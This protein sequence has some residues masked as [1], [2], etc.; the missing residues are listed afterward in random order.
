MNI[1]ID[2]E[3]NQI[4]EE[5]NQIEEIDEKP[6]KNKRNVKPLTEEQKEQKHILIGKARDKKTQYKKELQ[7]YKEK[8]KTVVVEQPVKSVEQ[9][10]LKPKKL[11]KQII[12]EVIKEEYESESEDTEE[13][14]IEKVIIKKIPRPPKEQSKNDMVNLTYRER[15]QQQLKEEKMKMIYNSLFDF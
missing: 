8:E 12:R 7:Q 1:Q 2:E 10:V 14:I 4:D 11:K 6:P 5:V 9:N 13:E 15:L 3:V